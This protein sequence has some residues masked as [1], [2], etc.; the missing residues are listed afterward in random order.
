MQLWGGS[1]G[2]GSG[3]GDGGG[4]GGGDGAL[5]L[6]VSPSKR[7]FRGIQT[8]VDNAVHGVMQVCVCVWGGVVGRAF[9][10][11]YSACARAHVSVCVCVCV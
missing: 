10:V 3:S 7:Y 9:G 11:R 8:H 4:G 5:L 6:V 2:G 1:S